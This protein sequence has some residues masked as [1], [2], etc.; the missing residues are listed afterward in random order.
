MRRRPESGTASPW[1]V[2][3]EVPP[4]SLTYW[5]ARLQQ[6]RRHA[7]A[8]LKR[9]SATRT[10][11][12]RSPHGF[13]LALVESARPPHRC[14]RRGTAARSRPSSQ[15]RGLHGAR[16][17]EQNADAH[18][19]LPHESAGLVPLAP[20]A[21]GR[22]MASEASPA[23]WTSARHQTSSAALGCR[24]GASPRVARARRRGSSW[25]CASSSKNRAAASRRSS[26][27]SGSSRCYFREPGGVLFEIATDGPGFAKD[28]D[29]A[30]LGEQLILPP[31]L[32]FQRGQIEDV[33]P[34]LTLPAPPVSRG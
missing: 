30:H 34:P 11:R 3:L 2:S 28:E 21:A 20:K 13:R 24:H 27:A 14:S 33:L 4:G 12:S 15:I 31:W 8:R 16:L 32:E 10:C 26:I 18:Q 5:G 6:L 25:R 19:P 1:R 9:G 23:S 22:A 17:W 7:S 29:P